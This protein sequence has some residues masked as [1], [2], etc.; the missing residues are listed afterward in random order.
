MLLLRLQFGDHARVRRRSV[1]LVQLPDDDR[2]EMEDC[3]KA[4]EGDRNGG[5]LHPGCCTTAVLRNLGGSMNELRAGGP[6]LTSWRVH[7]TTQAG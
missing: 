1:T 5:R 3:W 7:A 4:L 2:A 6:C